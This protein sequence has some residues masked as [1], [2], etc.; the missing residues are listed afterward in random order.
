[1]ITLAIRKLK[2][3]C[4]KVQEHIIGQYTI[5]FHMAGQSLQLHSDCG[6]SRCSPFHLQGFRLGKAGLIPTSPG[7]GMGVGK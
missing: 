2:Q 1:M 7:V 5:V 6:S 3:K 4:I